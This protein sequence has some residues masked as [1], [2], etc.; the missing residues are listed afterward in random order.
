MEPEV[1][2]CPKLGASQGV[3]EA[4]PLEPPVLRPEHAIVQHLGREEERSRLSE[5][6]RAQGSIF[7]VLVQSFF[8]FSS[9]SFFCFSISSRR[10]S[11]R[12]SASPTVISCS[13]MCVLYQGQRVESIKTPRKV[14]NP[15]STRTTPRFRPHCSHPRRTPQSPH[16]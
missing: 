10:S 5:E 9:C 12:R 15:A 7:L 11:T 6:H 14:Q 13:S 16:Q 2:E 3:R 8:A 1:R 4:C